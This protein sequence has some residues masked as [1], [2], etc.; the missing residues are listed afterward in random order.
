MAK[1][2]EARLDQSKRKYSLL[3]FATPAEV[4]GL[5]TQGAVLGVATSHSHRVDSVRAEPGHRRRATHLILSLFAMGMAFPT[6]S[7]ALVARG[8]RD[9][10]DRRGWE[11]KKKEGKQKNVC[12]Q[13][14]FS[15]VFEFWFVGA[16][17]F[18]FGFLC[19]NC[20][21]AGLRSAKGKLLSP[22]HAYYYLM[23]IGTK[24]VVYLPCLSFAS[25]GRA[26][27]LS[28]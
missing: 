3:T 27:G 17:F 8:P 23:N 15:K 11:R 12:P 20:Q 22:S 28:W 7:T 9:T 5:Q 24:C 13:N 26:F 18:I 10:H 25:T 16:L 14:T 4:T 6:C 1:R 19:H 2:K 21:K